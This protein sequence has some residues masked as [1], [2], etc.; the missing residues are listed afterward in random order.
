MRKPRAYSPLT[1]DA[2]LILGATVRAARRERRWTVD[3][4][5]ERVGVNH[6]TIRKVERGDLSVGLGT[7]F[8]AAALLGV[9]LFGDDPD[10]RRIEAQRLEDR[11][12]VLPRRVRRPVKVS[13]DF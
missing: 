12:A 3:E 4:L 1:R 8:E 7:A 5:A 13:N 9:P 11:L 6:T 2:A 10:R